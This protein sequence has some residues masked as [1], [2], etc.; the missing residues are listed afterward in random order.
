MRRKFTKKLWKAVSISQFLRKFAAVMLRYCR[1]YLLF[2]AFFL[3]TLVL[4]AQTVIDLHR[5]GTIRSKT[6]SDY[7]RQQR[8]N[9]EQARQDSLAYIDCLTRAF[10]ALSRGALD[11]AESLLSRALD[12]RPD[13]P[14]NYVVRHNLG[15]IA[16]ARGHWDAA[17][18]LLA[19]ALNAQPRHTALRLDHAKACYEAGHLPRCMDDTALLIDFLCT[20]STTEDAL[21][22]AL[23]LRAACH[24]RTGRKDLAVNDLRRILNSHPADTT[25]ALL[26]AITEAERHELSERYDAAADAYTTAI[27]LTP[28][29]GTLYAARARCYAKRRQRG[30]ARKDLETARD[31]GLSLGELQPIYDLIRP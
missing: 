11:D 29:D 1:L 12:L 14:S 21:T 24:D 13:A 15:K 25:A 20:D 3:P 28:R 17:E 9:A 31:C 16:M 7:D 6:L 23:M 8:G 2:A 30:L 19:A 18:R 5:G 4:S 10:N 22:E 26:L 27:A